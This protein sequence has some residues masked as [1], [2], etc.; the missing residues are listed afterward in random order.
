MTEILTEIIMDY[1]FEVVS[2]CS[3]AEWQGIFDAFLIDQ[4]AVRDLVKRIFPSS[5]GKVILLDDQYIFMYFIIDPPESNLRYFNNYFACPSKIIEIRSYLHENHVQKII[6]SG[7]FIICRS[8]QKYETA[9]IKYQKIG[10]ITS[11][12]SASELG[13]LRAR[14][15]ICENISLSNAKKVYYDMLEWDY[16]INTNIATRTIHIKSP[17]VASKMIIHHIPIFVGS[18]HF[19]AD[20]GHFIADDENRRIVFKMKNGLLSL[21]VD[22]SYV[23]TIVL[24]C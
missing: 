15:N 11:L 12:K 17:V 13:S 3:L 21:R 16:V 14:D 7:D 5:I 1:L 9:L 19:I 2:Y 20:D 18:G 22:C 24:I 10:T 6:V 8:L 4:A 23:K